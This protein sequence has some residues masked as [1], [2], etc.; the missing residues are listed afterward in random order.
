VPQFPLLLPPQAERCNRKAVRTLAS[1]SIYASKP[2][3]IH[4]MLTSSAIKNTA[5]NER[6]M[7]GIFVKYEKIDEE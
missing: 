3:S 4:S 6:Y 7:S 5:Q 1:V 2:N